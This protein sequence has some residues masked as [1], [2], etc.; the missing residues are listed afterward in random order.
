MAME[1]E[2]Q[3][4]HSCEHLGCKCS[5]T[6]GHYCGLFCQDVEVSED[7]LKCGCGHSQCDYTR[8]M[9]NESTFAPTGS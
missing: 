1:M 7:D 8:E 3:L 9:G 2:A 5:A 4:F 6:D